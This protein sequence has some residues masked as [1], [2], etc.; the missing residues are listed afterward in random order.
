MVYSLVWAQCLPV[1]AEYELHVGRELGASLT[2]EAPVPR[3]C[4]QRILVGGR[5]DDPSVWSGEPW[6]PATRKEPTRIVPY[7]GAGCG[8]RFLKG[9][10]DV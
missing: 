9:N 7:V 1:P 4:I 6:S 8:E 10:G 3:R 2:A 5:N